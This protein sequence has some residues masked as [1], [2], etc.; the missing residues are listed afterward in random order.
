[1][2]VMPKFE[3]LSWIG[4]LDKLGFS[5]STGSACSTGNGTNSLAA[6]SMN[7]SASELRRL[8]RISSYRDESA[9]H[10]QNLNAAIEQTYTQLEEE[11]SSSSV[12][13]L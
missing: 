7:L 9:E 1:M 13:S 10:W 3:N 6:S 2:L 4:K 5:V 12:I 8:I 11:A